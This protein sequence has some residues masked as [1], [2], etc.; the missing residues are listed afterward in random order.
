MTMLL[1]GYSITANVFYGTDGKEYTRSDLT[2]MGIYNPVAYMVPIGKAR[3][4]K[5]RNGSPDKQNPPRREN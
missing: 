4:T 2:L 1:D 5:E 3:I